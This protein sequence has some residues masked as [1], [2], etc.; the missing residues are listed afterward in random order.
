MN[1]S[2]SSG[3]AR[4]KTSSLAFQPSMNSGRPALR[5]RRSYSSISTGTLSWGASA[6]LRRD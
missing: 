3:A 2:V 4:V 1:T 5:N 6:V